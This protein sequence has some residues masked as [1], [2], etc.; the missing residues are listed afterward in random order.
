M[1]P[2]DR[3]PISRILVA[4]DGSVRAPGVFGAAATFAERF[5]ARLHV[6]RAVWLPP[7]FPAAGAGGPIDRLPDYA[8]REAARE[9]AAIAKGAVPAVRLEPPRSS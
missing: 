6:L 3:P 8:T 9:L 4:L 1:E 5:D 7:E 2:R